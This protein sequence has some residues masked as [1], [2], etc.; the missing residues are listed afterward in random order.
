MS[1]K[2]K[3]PRPR[4]RLNSLESLS[5]LPLSNTP[6]TSSQ[7]RRS[8]S[9]ATSRHLRRP[10][11]RSWL[12]DVTGGRYI[13]ASVDPATLEVNVTGPGRHWRAADRLS[14]GTSEQVYLLLRVA[15]AQHLTTTSERCPLLLDDVAVP[16][17]RRTRPADTRL[18]VAPFRRSAGRPVRTGSDR[19]C[20]GLRE[21][22]RQSRTSLAR[23]FPGQRR[24]NA[25][26]WARSNVDGG[27]RSD[28]GCATGEP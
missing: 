23:T 24:V 19:G 17:R 25:W 9:I 2:P 18:A 13:D 12:P 28:K 21:S 5:W 1:P 3:K 20:M 10:N 22:G 15:L 11:P 16:G 4:P 14:V 26:P 6:T 7:R 27:D 8:R